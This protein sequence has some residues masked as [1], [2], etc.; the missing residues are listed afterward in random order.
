M[1]TRIISFLVGDSYKPSFATI[2][3]KGD[4]PRYRKYIHVSKRFSGDLM[5]EAQGI[6]PHGFGQTSGGRLPDVVGLDFRLRHIRPV[7]LSQAGH[8]LN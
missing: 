5:T 8:P 6:D 7:S 1:T 2:T 4:N 3:G